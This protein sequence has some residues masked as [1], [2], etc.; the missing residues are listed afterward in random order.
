ML[1]AVYYNI[2]CGMHLHTFAAEV[3]RPF[4]RVRAP[5]GPRPP[6]AAWDKSALPSNPC[7]LQNLFL[8]LFSLGT[9]FPQLCPAPALSLAPYSLLGC[10]EQRA[11]REDK[12]NAALGDPS[13]CGRVPA[14]QQL[15]PKPSY[16]FKQFLFFLWVVHFPVGCHLLSPGIF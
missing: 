10:L 3:H 13:G 2:C 11:M 7:L 5:Q 9:R 1:V 14:V 12:G 6:V 16:T 15:E 4:Q 8:T